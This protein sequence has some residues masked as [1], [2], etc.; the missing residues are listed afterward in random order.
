MLISVECVNEMGKGEYD[1]YGNEDGKKYNKG[2]VFQAF[3]LT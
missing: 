2:T 1:A 3:H